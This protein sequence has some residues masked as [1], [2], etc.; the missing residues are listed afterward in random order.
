MSGKVYM[1]GRGV[2]DC[3]K[4]VPVCCGPDRIHLGGCHSGRSVVRL[5][6]SLAPTLPLLYRQ[7]FNSPLH[8]VR[9][10]AF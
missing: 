6:S 5:Q 10:T 1:G 7:L 9:P 2:A 8:D 4:T 3:C